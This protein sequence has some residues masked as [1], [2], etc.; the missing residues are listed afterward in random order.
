MTDYRI[1]F[2][3]GTAARATDA[4]PVLA[5]AERIYEKDTGRWKTGTGSDNWND[6]DYNDNTVAN[7]AGLRG[8]R[9]LVAKAVTSTSGHIRVLG[10][11]SPGDGGG[12]VFRWDSTDTST[13]DNGGTIIAPTTGLPGRWKRVYDGEVN[14]RWFGV[15]PSKSDNTAEL[16]AAI[17]WV[18]TDTTRSPGG[19]TP[20]GTVVIPLGY[21]RFTF[22]AGTSGLS[23]IT[24]GADNVMIRGEGRGTILTVRSNEAEDVDY[25]FTYTQS[26]R[27]SGGGLKD[28][29]FHGNS[30]LKWCI[31]L[32]TW[33]DAVFDFSASDV[34][35]GGL[36]AE[37]TDTTNLGE[38]I[39]VSFHYLP[40]SA[41]NSCLTQYGVRFRAGTDPE[42][43]TWSDCNIDKLFAVGIWDTGLVLDGV[44][45]CVGWDVRTS[46]NGTSSNTIDGEPKSGCKHAVHIANSIVKS[47][48][49]DVGQ[50]TIHNFYL[51]SH[52]GVED[53]NNYSGVLI[54]SSTG[55]TGNNRYN[56]IY[57]GT[58]SHSTGAHP[59]LIRMIDDTLTGLTNNNTFI[60]NQR[61]INSPTVII[62]L[63]VRDT[64]IYVDAVGGQLW[65]LKMID[66]G[67]RTFINDVLNGSYRLNAA[68]PDN[69]L[70]TAEVDTGQMTVD[71]LTGRVHFQDQYN[72]THR[73]KMLPGLDYV[74]PYGPQRIQAMPTPPAPRVQVLF[75]GSTTYSY[76]LV[77]VDKDGNQGVPSPVTTVTNGPA[78]LSTG[79]Y[80][81]ISWNPVEGAVKYDLL[82]G[83]TGQSVATNITA[84]HFTDTLPSTSAY[85]P[86][87][88]NPTGALAVDGKLTTSGGVE[89]PQ[90]AVVANYN[91]S[92]A[93]T[94]YERVRQYWNANI[95]LL[96]AE[97]GGTGTLRPIRVQG[98]GYLQVNPTAVGPTA[99]VVQANDSSGTASMTILGVNGTQ[100]AS[101]GV[102]Y[103]EAVAP[104]INQSGTAGYTA[105]LINPTE[106][107]TGSGVKKLIDAQVSGS[108]KFAVD[109]AGV[110]TATPSASAGT[111]VIRAAVPAS[112]GASG[113][114][115]SIAWDGSHIYVCTATNTWVRAALATW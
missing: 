37:S 91:T 39:R 18:A 32:D 87:S 69:T 3:R 72:D 58:I 29:L 83:S 1:Q 73:L 62:G 47:W 97:N 93:V 90:G 17:N 59:S 80:N 19:P 16:Q 61:G 13:P 99:G 40:T 105:L 23:T 15:H 94:N 70:G 111:A 102:Q 48:T 31:Y 20:G 28:L 53:P 6:L 34:H 56:R 38:D 64:K 4:N 57:N 44:V 50:H 67:T 106:T 92:D 63:G 76:Y 79:S 30:M 21:Y 14:A 108:T 88:V 110:V 100:S 85:T 42:S 89:T 10:Y 78:T 12:G 103:G 66:Q 82:R 35:G 96:S 54:S 84:T 107:A 115:G 11:Y 101:T 75:P 9:S 5:D 25:F 109:N 27:G 51:E 22:G 49:A 24:V 81:W 26:F 98:H 114:A 60:G 112:A 71:R 86:S 7:L 74:A 104:T 41:T 45:R 33:R 95:F 77:A 68:W 8:V 55:Q 52:A 43:T 2:R 65:R 46:W 113:V 36:D